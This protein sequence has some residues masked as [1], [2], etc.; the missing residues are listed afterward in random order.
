MATKINT[1]GLDIKPPARPEGLTPFHALVKWDYFE[2]T[3]LEKVANLYLEYR[4]EDEYTDKSEDFICAVLL[5]SVSNCS[6]K[7]KINLIDQL[8]EEDM[9][10]G[11]LPQLDRIRLKLFFHEM[12]SQLHNLVLEGPMFPEFEKIVQKFSKKLF[13]D[14]ALYK[15]LLC[16]DY[17]P[18]NEK[19]YV[20]NLIISNEHISI[21]IYSIAWLPGQ[22][23]EPHHHGEDL[24]A[25]IVI[26]GEL[27]HWP[28]Y[29]QKSEDNSPPEIYAKSS[30]V[31]VDSYR[32]HKL[33]SLSSM[34]KTIR[35]RIVGGKV[36]NKDKPCYPQEDIR[37]LF[38]RQYSNPD[39]ESLIREG[40]ERCEG[41]KT[42]NAS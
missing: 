37:C 2:R 23:T 13:S 9:D 25:I 19:G 31:T 8:I 1:Q 34:L 10:T 3:S 7:H 21:C 18:T 35:I 42:L 32:C 6:L 39:L 38:E 22:L 41:K 27:A 36:S 4:V 12:L 40:D 30:T 29:D 20:R 17:F 5:A 24:D 11:E 33:G 28:L 16:S 26:D 15:E 14:A